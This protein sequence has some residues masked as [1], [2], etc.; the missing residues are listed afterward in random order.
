MVS[1]VVIAI[2]VPTS[3]SA[4]DLDCSDFATQAAAQDHFIA[5]GGP[6]LD[7]D[8]LDGDRDGIACELLPCP[9]NVTGAPSTGG[10]PTTHGDADAHAHAADCAGCDATHGAG[11][12]RHRWRHAGGPADVG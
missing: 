5:L 4:A 2:A 10:V 7:P 12:A 6:A 1:A 3:A 11:P 9:C 8:R